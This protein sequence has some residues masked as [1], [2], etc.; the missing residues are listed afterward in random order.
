M[1]ILT[2]L[3][4][5]FCLGLLP[6]LWLSCWFSLD[7]QRAFAQILP[8]STL[9]TESSRIRSVHEVRDLI[10]GG[11]I[12]GRNLFHSFEAFNIEE[13]RE[14][15][16]SSSAA[17]ANIFSRIT[18]SDPSNIL[19]TLGV[20]GNANL[21]LLNP[22]GIIF[23]PDSQLDIRGS[24]V[25][26][27]G[28]R[29]TFPD[30]SSFSAVDPQTPPLLTINVPVGL[31]TSR[32][33]APLVNAGSLTVGQNQSLTLTGGIVISTGEL[34]AP[35][36][37]ISIAAIPGNS[38]VQLGES[39]E[40][41]T[42]SVLLDE[43]ETQPD[44]SIRSVTELLNM[45]SIETNH[46]PTELTPETALVSGSVDASDVEQQGGT[47][48]ILG[49]RLGIL[50]AEINTSGLFGGG[51]V[52]IGGDYQGRGTVPNASQTYI[53]PNSLIR[54]NA[55]EAGNGGNIIVWA[56]GATQFY[57]NISARGGA[58][59][60]N[61]GFAEVSGKQSL[62]FDGTADLSALN[63]SFGTLLLDPTNVLISN[64][65]DPGTAITQQTLEAISSQADVVV[66][67]DDNITIGTLDVRSTGEIFATPEDSL[68]S[69]LRFSPGPGGSIVFRADANQDGVGNFS[70][71]RG[72]FIVA[73]QRD[74]SISGANIEAGTIVSSSPVDVPGTPGRISLSA[75]NSVFATSLESAVSLNGTGNGTAIVVQANGDITIEN[76]LRSVIADGARGNAGR[77]FVE[78]RSGDVVVGSLAST[79]SFGNGGAIE[80]IAGNNI[81]V[82]NIN[83]L[84]VDNGSGGVIE[85]SAGNNITAN[86]I[87][88]SLGGSVNGA[89]V[90][91][92][93][94][95]QVA[96]NNIQTGSGNLT[97]RGSTI[98]QTAGV[99][100]VSG[101]ASFTSTRP[102]TGNVI[103]RN[104][105]NNVSAN[106]CALGTGTCLGNSIIGGNLD[107]FSAGVVSQANNA[108]LQVAGD[109]RVNN[110]LNL[111]LNNN[112]NIVPILVEENGGITDVTLTQVGQ[113]NITDALNNVLPDRTITGDFT[114][115]SLETGRAEFTT[116]YDN[117]GTAIALTGN[118]LFRGV[119][120]LTTDFAAPTIPTGTPEIT[121]SQPVQVGGI[122]SFNAGLNGNISL[123]NPGNQFNQLGFSGRT[124][125][126]QGDSAVTFTSVRDIRGNQLQST[127][128]GN[129]TLE[130]GGAILQNQPLTVLGNA[131]FTSRLANAGTVAVAN[132]DNIVLENS[133]IG[134][135]LFITSGGSVSQRPGA[136]L[137]VA[138]DIIAVEAPE[139]VDLSNSSNTIPDVELSNGDVIITRVGRINLPTR[140]VAGN[141]TVNSVATGE[142][143]VGAFPAAAITLNHPNNVFNGAISLNTA[144]P[145]TEPISGT[146]GITQ[147]GPQVVRGTATFNATTGNII[148]NH[149]A[150]RLGDLAFRGNN[151]SI[152]ENASINLLDSTATGRLNLISAG[153]I[154]QAGGL[155]VIGASQFRTLFNSAPI[156]LTSTNNRLVGDIQLIPAG[157]GDVAL[158]NSRNTQLAETHLRGDLQINTGG[159][160]TQS[161]RLT[162]RGIATLNAEENIRLGRSDNDFGIVTIGEVQSNR[163]PISG[164]ENVSLRDINS[165]TLAPVVVN[166]SLNVR[167]ADTIMVPGESLVT[168][169]G[170]SQ[171]NIEFTARSVTL[172]NGGTVAT[173]ATDNRLGGNIFINASESV[174]LSGRSPISWGISA[175]TIGS[176]RDA[177]EVTINTS[178]LS[179]RDGA[180][181]SSSVF[182]GS[183][184]QGGAV[185]INADLIEIEGTFPNEERPSF[186]GATTAGAGDGGNVLINTRDLFVR[187]G[188]VIGTTSLQNSTGRGGNLV[189]DAAETI[190][191]S[192]TSTNARIPSVISADTFSSERS[193]D[194]HLST[195]QLTIRDG[196]AVSVSTLGVG[197]GGQLR[198]SASDRLEIRGTAVT[199][200]PS[201]LYAQSFAEGTA[202]SFRVRTGELVIRNGGVITVASG[203]I[204]D[205]NST[206]NTDVLFVPKGFEL[207]DSQ[208]ATGDAGEL[209]IEA[210]SIWISDRSNITAETASGEGGNL[211][212]SVEEILLLRNNSDLRTT[213]RGTGNG[214]N[215]TLRAGIGIFARLPEDSDVI[216][217][218]FA[219]NGGNIFATAPLILGFRQ[220]EG[221][222]TPES[223]FVASS[224]LGRDGEI[225]LDTED[226]PETEDLPMDWVTPEI[227]QGCLTSRHSTSAQ[228]RDVGQGGLSVTPYEPL[229]SSGL[230]DDIRLPQSLNLSASETEPNFDEE[231]IRTPEQVTEQ[232]VEPIAEADRW[233]VDETG[234]II[235][236]AENVSV[237][238]S[239]NAAMSN[240]GSNH[241]SSCQTNS[242]NS[243]E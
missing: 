148:L 186:L 30:G 188:A 27:T 56:D 13:G 26:S 195:A 52:L 1:V 163:V 20:L 110:E 141:L 129:L 101:S 31:Q 232:V 227:D 155:E 197:D 192:G 126:I 221:V 22:N 92:R 209:E 6:V 47:V 88:S 220:F 25:V 36:G 165:L 202:G 225:T 140:R 179:I 193:G 215:I 37:Q 133:A 182:A 72:H 54:A 91:L 33:P 116:V 223:D 9:G 114:V 145:R 199:G 123:N 184:G 151:V 139:G 18:G 77:I 167:A 29:F 177:G 214:G 39:G 121:Q 191:I 41:L 211:N 11:A 95:N 67:A 236:L 239:V 112:Q 73:S 70:M 28:D 132:T 74:I 44:E 218:A 115:N 118:N 156:L 174:Q 97:V 217:N 3:K 142:R 34:T 8:D 136:V 185:A 130:F 94:G 181:I 170:L 83:S 42:W 137:R 160:I 169:A 153:V 229:S 134:G 76:E 81:V 14:A 119:L 35:G 43:P 99:I 96:I 85:L 162:I 50:N 69:F 161:G 103:V 231:S 233:I 106:A 187:N 93:A 63:G 127:A 201:G 138:G 53:S 200:F 208:Q 171:G 196:G 40:L 60:G 212:I 16:F 210:E 2:I 79:A 82:G 164:A 17:I 48:Q 12:R 23:G 107:L 78:S 4:P 58:R 122:A 24:L 175:D 113:I 105:L 176:N 216:A 213:A 206:V 57:G 222:E 5:L 59:D 238:A 98:T 89:A 224:E 66:Q 204:E 86:D 75:S 120:S 149:S 143:F 152:R 243:F 183:T 55:I 228:F 131:S 230:V 237:N 125:E 71:N 147:S 32:Q 45:A 111:D 219:G 51:T 65:S 90:S 84:S 173:T 159:S 80:V 172:R 242:H 235:L 158:F 234:K 135:N 109:V 194:I 178:R 128:N 117:N 189:I 241:L 87:Y 7:K 207:P 104:T 102:E 166:G 190:E 180:A 49:D 240:E 226:P 108:F 46:L 21:F 146:P 62:T 19:G 144:L 61:G 203:S 150:N 64:G 157:S 154:T 100:D 15:Y 168:A 68:I 205:P 10:E 198:V 38:L 124:V